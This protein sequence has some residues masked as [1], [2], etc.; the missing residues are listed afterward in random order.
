QNALGFD[1]EH[2]E[3]GKTWHK[4]GFVKSKANHHNS[5]NLLN[6]SFIDYSP[7]NGE[8]FYRLKQVDVDGRFQYSQIRMV[9]FAGKSAIQ[10]HPNPVHKAVTIS[11]LSGD[12]KIVITNVLGQVVLKEN[13]N[14]EK[15]IRLN[16]S[17]LNSGV[18]FISIINAQ[19][20]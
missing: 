11:G 2:S 12:N 20:G 9:N 5:N 17:K 8:N 1:I 19:N 15:T 7:V 16:T 4:I 10:I 18:Y 14:S 3:E 13:T 6:Y